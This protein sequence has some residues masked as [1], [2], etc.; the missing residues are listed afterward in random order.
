VKSFTYHCKKYQRTASSEHFV[1]R[2][3]WNETGAGKQFRPTA[4]ISEDRTG[5][6]WDWR[7]LREARAGPSSA[8]AQANDEPLATKSHGLFLLGL[9][10][11]VATIGDAFL[12]KLTLVFPR[13]FGTTGRGIA[14]LKRR[15]L[16]RPKD[17]A[18]LCHFGGNGRLGEGRQRRSSC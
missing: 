13:T 5:L 17:L 16:F 6:G 2:W 7:A 8:A 3:A 1:G 18:L 12:E 10:I 4:A 15:E 9:T 11:H 14:G